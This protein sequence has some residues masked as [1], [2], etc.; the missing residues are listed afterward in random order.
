MIISANDDISPFHQAFNN[1]S[2]RRSSFS[3]PIGSI[4]KQATVT[5][6]QNIAAFESGIAACDWRQL[7]F[8]RCQLE[9]FQNQLCGIESFPRNLQQDPLN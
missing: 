2:I 3:G 6:G 8:K 4:H 5:T 9:N 7:G 1:R